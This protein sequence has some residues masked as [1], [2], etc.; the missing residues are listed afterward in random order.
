MKQL[1]KSEKPREE[2][3]P[4]SVLLAI[5]VSTAIGLAAYFYLQ[6]GP[7]FAGAWDFLK[8]LIQ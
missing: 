5:V 3:L 1:E 8:A 4:E 6:V 7:H 2:A